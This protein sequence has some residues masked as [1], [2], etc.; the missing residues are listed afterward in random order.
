[1]SA[2]GTA[3]R[4]R[5][6]AMAWAVTLLC[7]G[8]PDRLH[9]WQCPD[10]TPPPCAAARRPAARRPPPGPELRRRSFLVL[11]FR[12][13][14]RS[15][16]HDWLVEGSPVMIADALSR[17]E[18][19]TVVPDERLYP[20][21]R[22]E[23]LRPGEVM[24]LARVRRVASETGGWTAVTGDVLAIGNRVRVSA[25]AFDVVSNA[26]V[27]RVV[28]DAAEGED[29]RAVFQ[30][31]GTRLLRTAGLDT[32]VAA[33]LAETTTGS[34][35][36]YRAYLRGVAHA[37]R[38]E[39]RRARDAFLEA[40]RLDSAF[41]QAYAKLAEATLNVNPNSLL[42]PG[43]EAFRY[44]ARAAELGDR[45]P[46]R[47]RELIVGIHDLLSGRFASARSRF[48][49]LVGQDSANVDALEWLMSVE[50]FDPILAPVPGGERPRG[51]LNT[52]IRLARRTLDLDPAR[53]HLYGNLIQFY[54]LAGGGPPGFLP[55]YRREAP[56]PQL[57]AS[58]PDAVFTPLLADTFMLVP[59]ESLPPMPA[60][61]LPAARA[62]AIAGARAWSQHWL[63]VGRGEAD[64]HLWASRV[65]ELEGDAARA[66]GALEAADSLGV[67]TGLENVPARRMGLLAKLGRYPDGT[68]IADSLW[69][70][71]ALNAAAM[72]SFQ[73]GSL[74]WAFTL[75]VLGGR[76]ERADTII[77]RTA[78]VL[79]ASAAAANQAPEAL[80]ITF[81]AGY[82]RPFFDTPLEMRERVLER[83]LG[84]AARLPAGSLERVLPFHVQLVLS[85]AP[86]STRGR[87]GARALATAGALAA[88]GRA[89]LAFELATAAAFRDSLRR[90]SLDSTDWY[91]RR[92]DAARA[93]RDATRLRF[94]ALRA[95]VSEQEAVFSWAAEGTTFTW[96]RV[97]AAIG[98]NEYRWSAEFDA[99]GKRY[100]V[101]GRHDRLPASRARQGTL[102]E[103][104][105]ASRRFLY[106][107]AG[108]S[109][110]TRRAVPGA[111]V[112]LEP[113]S[114][115]FRMVLRD[116][117]VVAALRR[118]RPAT[119]SFR[120]APCGEAP[121][122][123]ADCAPEPIPVTYP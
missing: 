15:A 119:V 34:L 55:A 72:N 57:L 89:D 41:A 67:E 32:A 45:L 123:A 51:S 71:G 36:A 70:A 43:G 122:R 11:P 74:G 16:D 31:L 22:R 38:S 30:R 19:V 2:A 111:L 64:S 59:T 44:A 104:L 61:S 52:A 39:A 40:I 60:E 121:G 82:V 79:A 120:F 87:I 12:N 103:L 18:E 20:A 37:N 50:S 101:L 81:L 105:G 54:L 114:A 100:E 58:R 46:A 90:R 108:D 48:A 62:R 49:G 80:A 78:A 42:D 112:R 27:V 107:V 3:P 14:S 116:T 21:L 93:E 77:Q 25:R 95:S 68:R 28:E 1:M 96:N 85:T 73:F 5:R 118:E 9:A 53:H 13:V 26:E 76:H 97:E 33:D 109:A 17:R 106:E 75:F 8:S 63:R 113:D 115:G 88:G 99:G 29:V 102:A 117:S 110:A 92:R 4:A 84:D 66:L 6:Q 91:A 65:F 10:G 35:A 56:L 69:Q 94:R 83:I 7:A 98:E 86:D 23:G 24:D 47:D